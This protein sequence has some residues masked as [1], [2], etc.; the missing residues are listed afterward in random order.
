[1]ARNRLDLAEDA[2]KIDGQFI[3]DVIS[4]FTTLSSTGRE[5]LTREVSTTSYKKDGSVVNYVRYPERTIVVKFVIQSDSNESY[6]EKYSRLLAMFDGAKVDIQFNDE[7][8][9]FFTGVVSVNEPEK[10]YGL[11]CI[12][13]YT[14]KCANPFKYSTNV[15]TA[16]P[17][18][19]DGS[20]AQFLINY[21]GNYPAKPILEA[22]FVGALS[23]GNYSDDGDCGFVAFMDD[24]ENIIQLG[25][26]DAVDFDDSKQ[27]SQ[28]L[29]RTFTTTSGFS[30]TGGHTWGDKT[31]SGATTANYEVSDEYWNRGEGQTLKCVSPVFAQ[32]TDWH[33]PILRYTIPNGAQNF[34]VSLV[35]RLACNA[36]EELGSFECGVYTSSGKML[37]GFVIE[38][39]SNGTSGTLRYIVNGAQKGGVNIDLS[40]YNTNFGRCR[41]TPIYEEYV[42]SQTETVL[43]RSDDVYDITEDRNRGVNDGYNYSQANLN[44]YI[45]RLGDSFTFKVGNLPQ[46]TFTLKNITAK[47]SEVSMHFGKYNNN[48]PISTNAVSSLKITRLAGASFADTENVFTAGDIVE[49]NCSDASIYLK[50]AGTVDG[51]LAAQYGALANDWEGFKLKQGANNIQAAWSSWVNPTYKPQVRIKYSEVYL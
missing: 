15:I 9:K 39:S 10:K 38:K 23:G 48:Y 12:G 34:E 28:I 24:R 47:A 4:G 18:S 7:I 5:A 32:G 19:Y 50:R 37:A 46:V 13:S 31:I 42:V 14:V 33:G 36:P 6:R 8:D 30:T 17:V 25:N 27:A 43:I 51:Q 22:E 49:A 44:S 3:E 26:P 21:H 16:T 11:A 35:H 2:A 45:K 1:M 41:R 40:Y 20:T 29:N